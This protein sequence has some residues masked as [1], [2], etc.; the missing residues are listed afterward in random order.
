VD[1]GLIKRLPL[2]W[3]IVEILMGHSCHN[4][5]CLYSNYTSR[6][7]GSLLMRYDSLRFVP[8]LPNEHRH[9]YLLRIS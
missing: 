5:G 4:R 3:L 6:L 9:D 7:F 1:G 2:K 8:L